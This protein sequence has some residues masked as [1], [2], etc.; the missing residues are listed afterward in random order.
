MHSATPAQSARRIASLAWP[1]LIGQLA[2]IANGVIDTAMTSRFSATDLAALAIGS[3]IYVSVFVSGHGVLQALSPA[4]SQM[5]GARQL[6]AIG[7]EVKQ[8]AWLA[9]FLSLLGCLIL[10]FPQPLLALTHAS[11]ELIDK[12]THYLRIL[13]IALPATLAFRVYSAL[14]NALARPKMV[15]AIHLFAVLL[16]I[17][18]NAV[19]IFGWAGMPAF[20]GPGAAIGTA[21][22][23]W[24]TLLIA[25]L[26]LKNVKFYSAFG[27]F[28][29]GFVAPRWAALRSTLRLGVPIGLS[30]LI[31][32]SA[33]TFMAIFIARLGTTVVGGH[34]ITANFGTILYM[35]PLSIASA[36]G[37]LV[38]HAIGAHNMDEARRIGDSG[39]RLAG[40]IAII[41]GIAVWL[42]RHIIVRAYTPDAAVA[43]AALPLF[44]FVALYQIF[45]AVQVTAAFILRAYKIA[46]VPTV[47]YAV[48]LWGVGLGGGYVLGLDPFRIMPDAVRGAAGFWIGNTISLILV[49]TG[50]MWYLRAIQRAAASRH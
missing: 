21:I 10:L 3:S 31:E 19:F 1:I 17:P 39:L 47:I 13:A 50:L 49:A 16:K 11:P 4:I 18:L 26:V 48:A 25:W 32:V 35:L 28:G 38:A 5:F 23:S 41:V 30:Y 2:V 42:S 22:L 20:G 29:T 7:L 24:L 43:A 45:D 27:L 6:D 37:T 40:L 8:G 44:L 9:L 46:I 34:Q 36:T 14:N 15:M 12:A 33:F